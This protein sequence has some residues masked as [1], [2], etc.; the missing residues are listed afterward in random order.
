M[1]SVS[2]G[3][4]GWHAEN[5]ERCWCTARGECSSPKSLSSSVLER[6]P[7]ALRNRT[8]LRACDA[9]AYQ[10]DVCGEFLAAPTVVLQKAEDQCDPRG[11]FVL[12]SRVTRHVKN[13]RRNFDELKRRYDRGE[14]VTNDTTRP[15]Y[16][17]RAAFG[18]AK[19]SHQKVIKLLVDQA[20]VMWEEMKAR[21]N[22]TSAPARV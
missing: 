7:A 5:A 20:D 15:S 22:G 3:D 12:Q 13:A 21:G 8:Y 2:V 9:K 19:P 17:I 11:A 16:E 6:S 18:R 4:V 1:A 14:G 10:C